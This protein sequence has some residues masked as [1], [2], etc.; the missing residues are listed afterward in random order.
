MSAYRI[1]QEAVSNAAR[2]APGTPVS[3]AV[4]RDG[5][6]VRLTVDNPAGATPATAGEPGHG[7]RG[8]RERVAMLDGELSAGPR[9]DGGFTVR[10]SLPIGGTP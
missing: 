4:H 2:H 8:M 1:I 9:D 5:D 10:A 7:L 6:G 3:V